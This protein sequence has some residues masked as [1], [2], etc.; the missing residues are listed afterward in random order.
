MKNIDTLKQLLKNKAEHI[1]SN[2]ANA[3]VLKQQGQGPIAS[4]IHNGLVYDG[5]DYRN[6]H[7]AY[8]ELRGKTRDQIEK[9]KQDNPPSE[10]EIK[11]IKTLYA[12][13][14][15]EILAYNERKAKREET[16][17]ANK[18]GS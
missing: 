8:C 13:T 4:G 15:E 7:I 6:H 17:R 10:Y 18:I 2:R 5:K 1:R 12:W 16:L 11:R 9:P 14:P 3:R